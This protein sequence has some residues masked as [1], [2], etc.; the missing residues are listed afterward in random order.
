MGQWCISKDFEFDFGHRVWTQKLQTEFSLDSACKCKHLHGHRGKIKVNLTGAA[1]QGGMLTDFKHLNVFRKFVDDVL[2]HK[3]LFDI[4]DPLVNSL[5]DQS[6]LAKCLVTKEFKG[7]FS[8]QVIDL[9]KISETPTLLSDELVEFYEGIVFLDFVP[10]AENLS[11]YF[12][13]GLTELLKGIRNVDVHSVTFF[14][15]PKAGSTYF[16]A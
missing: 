3:F 15:T 12:S 4:H 11:S 6:V 9:S 10:T 8:Y 14:E 2:D 1:L 7:A 5:F 16:N 13:S